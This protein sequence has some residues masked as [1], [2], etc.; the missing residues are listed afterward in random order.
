[1]VNTLKNYWAE[2]T[3][4]ILTIG[5][6]VLLA[7]GVDETIRLTPLYI[8]LNT[9][10]LIYRYWSVS[11]IRSILVTAA[12]VGFF[13]ELIGVQTGIL[14][15]DYIYGSVLGL[16]IFDV[17]IMVGVMWALVMMVVWSLIPEKW[18]LYKIPVAGLLAVLYDLVLEHFATRFDLWTWDGSI[19]LSNYVGWFVVSSLIAAVY[20]YKGYALKPTFMSVI[21]MPLHII[22]FVTALVL[23]GA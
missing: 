2:V 14:F 22:F 16:K 15:G 23:I 8:L 3:F 6:I 5:G 13:A 10:I 4:I 20:T 11:Y 17:P 18:R 7:F 21:T 1:M 19:P 12:S 9:G